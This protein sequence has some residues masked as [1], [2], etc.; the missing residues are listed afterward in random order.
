MVVFMWAL[1]EYVRYRRDLPGMSPAV[2]DNAVPRVSPVVCTL[3]LVRV[4]MIRI[5]TARR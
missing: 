5:S 2:D 4:L 1:L 3:G